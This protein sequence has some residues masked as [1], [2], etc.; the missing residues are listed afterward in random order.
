MAMI[1]QPPIEGEYD[2]VIV[3]SGGGS[4]C[5]ALAAKEA[6]KTAIILEKQPRLGGSTSLSGGVW[7]IPANPLLA[8]AGIED[9]IDKGRQYLDALV[10]DHGGGASPARRE[11]FLRAAP[12]MIRFLQR[13]GMKIRRPLHVWPDYY[14]D[15]PGGLPQGRSLMPVPFNLKTLGPWFER[16]ATYTPIIP[17]PLGS[18]EFV[19][20]LLMKRTM[21]G[22]LKALKLAWLMLRAKLFKE[23]VSGTGAGIQGRMLEIALRQGLAPYVETPVKEF[24]VEDGRVAGVIAS[25]EGKRVEIRARCGVLLDTGGFSRNGALREKLARSPIA[26]N[27]TSANRGDTGDLLE[28]MMALGAATADL[29]TAWWVITSR[30]TNGEWP[31]EAY[32]PDG[33]LFPF[34]HHLEVSLPHVILV[35]QNGRRF[36][37]EAGSYMDIGEA[38]YERHGKTG[39][40]I[41]AWAIFDARHRERYHWGPLLPG[42]TP[43]QWIDSGYMKKAD[44]LDELARLCG[45]DAAGLKAETGRFN[46]F[47]KTGK[48]LDYKRGG[49]AFDRSHGDP[50]V[51]PNPCLGAIEQGPFYATAIYPGDVGTAGGV[52]TDEHARVVR[53]D[54]SPIEGLYA[55]GNVTAP[56]F[57]RNYPGAGA[58]IAA[59]FTFGYIAAR[60]C[61]GV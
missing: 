33:N 57:G 32:T 45:I 17:V 6:G 40:G 52:I 24:I 1:N 43:Q 29:D 10:G 11:A 49:R 59:S 3:G 26:G 4:M 48:D 14:D 7:W 21:A 51:K 55:C 5:A 22:K 38:L 12:E 37:N 18:D 53:E 41:P 2:L 28:P 36:C 34:Q 15:L 54:G 58:S 39:R 8:K 50:T 20:L 25:H 30:N 35:D 13:Q 16:V 19:S 60:H 42:K 9:S 61:A 44:S 23:Q 31:P 47:C 56:V 27:W 46:E